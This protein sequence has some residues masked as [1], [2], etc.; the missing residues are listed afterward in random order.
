MSLPANWAG[1]LREWK[2]TEILLRATLEILHVEG[3]F[4]HPF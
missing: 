1:L 2:I 4:N 3:T